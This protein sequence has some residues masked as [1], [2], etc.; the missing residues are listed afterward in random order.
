M[1]RKEVDLSPKVNPYRKIPPRLLLRHTQFGELPQPTKT[2][3]ETGIEIESEGAHP[4][5][6]KYPDQMI[7]YVCVDNYVY[8]VPYV[9]SGHTKFLKTIIP[10]RKATKRLLGEKNDEI[11]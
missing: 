10:S 4:N 3:I 6:V 2:G 9:Q 5:S 11:G 8:L 1:S 7:L